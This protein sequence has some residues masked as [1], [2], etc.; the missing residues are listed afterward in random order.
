[1]GIIEEKKTTQ[2]PDRSPAK[3]DDKVLYEETTT[4][5]DPI[6]KGEAFATVAS[7]SDEDGE[8]FRK[9][10][11]LDPDT[12]EHWA[13]VYEKSRYECRAQFDPAFTWTEAEEKKLVRRLDWH[14][15]LWAVRIQFSS[16]WSCVLFLTFDSA[17][18]SSVYKSIAVI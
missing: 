15:C 14:V 17:L 2:S 8:A 1:M 5:G 9:N 4:F 3:L 13:N 6:P 16:V 12:A 18:C 11:F 7:D 10:P